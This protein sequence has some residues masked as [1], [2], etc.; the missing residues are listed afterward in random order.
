MGDT[1]AMAP[2]STN[3]NDA[4]SLIL[5]SLNPS[6]AQKV[7][8]IQSG[9]ASSLQQQ[10]E[11]NKAAASISAAKMKENLGIVQSASDAQMQ[12]EVRQQQAA[13]THD[14]TVALGSAA[15][16][17]QNGGLPGDATGN[18]AQTN[19][20]L[21]DIHN[22]IIRQYQ[23]ITQINDDNSIGG[24]LAQMFVQ[25]QLFKGMDIL[26]GMEASLQKEN[27]DTIHRINDQQASLS[28]IITNQDVQGKMAANA[29]AAAK[30]QAEI[31]SKMLT[32]VGQ[33]DALRISNAE[34]LQGNT[35]AQAAARTAAIIDPINVA[36]NKLAMTKDAAEI[37][38][39]NEENRRY[40]DE[41]NAIAKIAQTTGMEPGLLRSRLK[42]ASPDELNALA[43]FS[44]SG[45]KL[46]RPS[47][48]NILAKWV[49]PDSDKVP[50]ETKSLIEMGNRLSTQIDVT[51]K[52]WQEYVT[53]KYSIS[54][55]KLGDA[56]LEQKIPDA[57]EYKAFL[58]DYQRDNHFQNPLQDASPVTVISRLDKSNQEIAHNSF[59][60]VLD[61][62]MKMKGSKMNYS[63]NNLIQQITQQYPDANPA[64]VTAQLQAYFQTRQQLG[65]HSHAI[66]AL[67]LPVP[68]SDDFKG[69]IPGVGTFGDM[70]L[71]GSKLDYGDMFKVVNKLYN[72]QLAA[73]TITF[74]GA[75]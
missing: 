45:G 60:L 1:T 7:G 37:V 67:G 4:A 42:F 54:N 25:P 56:L 28:N 40:L 10:G 15:I 35:V 27:E 30:A 9:L 36:R 44:M 33:D 46:A 26:N 43:S 48:I 18:I 52:A 3:G 71:K 57:T 50:V 20:A 29:I 5:N 62:A 74:M 58:H 34:L 68:D 59:P 38:K 19:N 16:V 55:P 47:D 21:S 63:D 17:A 51:N 6:D 31:G 22:R 61:I 24:A 12:A 65:A 41:N 2:Q 32:S 73:K 53:K 39:I 64:Q 72:Q 70:D 75:E 11:Q 69:V 13:D 49:N 66:T 8:I 23:G 14:K